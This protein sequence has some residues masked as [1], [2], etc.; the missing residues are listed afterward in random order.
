MIEP[1]PRLRGETAS[2]LEKG[3]ASIVT[4]FQEFIRDQ[5]TASLLLLSCTLIVLIIANSPLAEQYESLVETRIGIVLGGSDFVM[6][7]RHW[8][9]DGLMALF[10]FVLGLEIKRELLVGELREPARS[11]PVVAAAA[12]GML[13]PALL[14]YALNHGGDTIQGWAIPMATD[15]AFAIG[16]LALLG[17]RIPAA[18]T[19]F[20][21][22]LA[23]I[24]DLGAV[25][26]IALFYTGTI[27]MLYL[28][29][30]LG[31]LIVLVIFNLLGV[32]HPIVFFIGGSLVWLAMLGS[33]VHATLAGILVAMTVPARPARSPR[34]FV[35]RSR[36]LID[37]FEEIDTSQE[38][39]SPI[40][41]EPQKHNVVE[42]LQETASQATTPLQLWE[43][44]LEHPVALFVLPLFA[45]VNAGIAVEP[46]ALQAHIA[47]PLAMGIIVGLVVGKFAGISLATLAVLRLGLGQLPDGMLQH[48]IPG[49]GLLGGIGFTMS[50]FI[51]GLG[52][53][54][55]PEQL[56]IAKTGI[57][58]ASLIAGLAGYLWLRFGVPGHSSTHVRQPGDVD[59]RQR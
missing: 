32:R 2:T 6:S 53:S 44:T 48:H 35:R 30:A 34:A 16:I 51:A 7:L 25:L 28:G 31:L 29:S 43:R 4:P 33:G 56:L 46:A 23:I 10:F 41:A 49:L 20:L 58:T 3:F 21:L 22:A 15:T 39:T 52:F 17:T 50:I 9:N 1:S 38:S 14:F 5:K 11:I 59:R 37:E 27:S 45:L 26:V 19:T 42:R 57:L 8:V 18:L 24:D 54:S 55:Q 13:V 47:D 12:G 40:L 36:Q